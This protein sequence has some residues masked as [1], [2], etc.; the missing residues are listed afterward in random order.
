MSAPSAGYD[1]LHLGLHEYLM[2]G[3][4]NPANNPDIVMPGTPGG[5]Q[6][7]VITLY[8]L[9]TTPYADT[10]V[11]DP[12]A[13]GQP[14]VDL[15]TKIDDFISDLAGYDTNVA[16]HYDSVLSAV[17]TSW[18]AI[19]GTAQIDDA[20]DAFAEKEKDRLLAALGE[21]NSVFSEYESTN[22]S[23]RVLGAIDLYEKHLTD[24]KNF[25]GDLE[26]KAYLQLNELKG[27]SAIELIRYRLQTRADFAKLLQVRAAA[28]QIH[29][30]SARLFY[31][32]SLNSLLEDTLWDIK[33]YD[34]FIRGLGAL[35]GTAVIPPGN[36]AFSTF[37]SAAGAL[38]PLI[39][40]AAGKFL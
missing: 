38:S 32:D 2:T 31:Q 9:T 4:I 14:M 16:S 35:T 29:V 37:A 22:S 30:E 28:S 15:V 19:F 12:F 34:Y 27:N 11:Y 36:S 20:V 40:A 10:P 1:P 3:A 24:V 33:S 25:R 21:L 17:S 18:D 13:T 6:E 23:A 39:I 26:T 5:L 8:N 7:G